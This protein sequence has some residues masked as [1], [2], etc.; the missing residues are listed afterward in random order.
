MHRWLLLCLLL[1]TR[2]VQAR[3][4]YFIDD[5]R[6]RSDLQGISMPMPAGWGQG[7][8]GAGQGF[9]ARLVR[10]SGRA[11]LSIF[12]LGGNGSQ[13]FPS[14]AE[15]EKELA[16]AIRGFQVKKIVPCTL[17][18]MPFQ[19]YRAIGSG[20]SRQ[21]SLYIGFANER[22]FMFMLSSN[23]EDSVK[24]RTEVMSSLKG[25]KFTEA[26]EKAPSTP[27]NELDPA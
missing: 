4:A 17:G 6:L 7:I 2:S 24:A 9:L 23:L 27:T 16:R 18:S 8:T 10:A 3:P 12:V 11:Q 13:G 21:Y 22:T 5:G 25:I 1:L 15:I 14:S 19:E 20:G 26:R